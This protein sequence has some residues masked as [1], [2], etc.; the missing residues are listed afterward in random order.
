LDEINR[1]KEGDKKKQNNSLEWSSIAM[2][3]LQMKAMVGGR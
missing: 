2:R 3:I 1:R